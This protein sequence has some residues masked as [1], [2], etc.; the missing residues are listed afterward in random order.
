M[1]HVI[2]EGSNINMQ[3]FYKIWQVNPITGERKLLRDAKNLILYSGADLLAAAMAGVN[4]TN[5]SHIYVGYKNDVNSGFTKP[6][7]DKAYS[8]KFENYGTGTTLEDFGYFRIPLAYSP[9]F[10][11][12]PNYKNNVVVFTGIVTGNLNPIGS[13]APFKDSLETGPN[14]RLFEI[15]LVSATEP[16]TYT[17]DK[18]F[19]RANFE[20][21]LFNPSYNL[22]IS[23]GIQFTA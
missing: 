9:T 13:S 23:W 21:L 18:I 3:G 10:L 17:G 8:T 5:I 19:S 12:Q 4:Y 15:A 14:S 16:A 1:E 2:T 6:N 7:I 11:N 22:T 20:P